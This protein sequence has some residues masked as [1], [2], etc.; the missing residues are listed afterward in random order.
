MIIKLENVTKI[1]KIGDSYIKA[2]D[3]INLEVEE[4]EL[5]S[6]MGPSGS[7][8]STLL[9]IIGCLDK[10]TS[11]KINL[12]GFDILKLSDKELSKIRKNYIG[13][14]FQQ[15][16]LFNYLNALE[17]VELI[18][19]IAN[20][21]NNKAKELLEKVGLGNRLYNLPNQL[22]GGQQQRVV[23][24]RALANDPKLILADEPTGNL[25]EKSANDVIDILKKLNKEEGKTIAIVTHDPRIAE[26]T[27]R[28]V[29]I[30][31]GK[32]LSDNTTVDEALELLK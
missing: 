12:F 18:T 7:G 11:G 14:I 15:F 9:S 10:P 17:N 2:L 16:Y 29:V 8:K 21:K 19:K 13:F 5:I 32:I 25:D 20:K 24:A 4:G 30:R 3:N 6:I 1:Y 22:S 27:E 28:I 31:N 23:I 26:Q